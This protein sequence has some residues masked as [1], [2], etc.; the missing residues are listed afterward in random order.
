MKA[1]P[2]ADPPRIADIERGRSPSVGEHLDAVRQRTGSP[3]GD[4]FANGICERRCCKEGPAID[5]I[6]NRNVLADRVDETV[7]MGLHPGG[8]LGIDQRMRRASV[9]RQR[10]VAIR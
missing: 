7:I 6:V 10:D 2:D 4:C 3:V 1:C 5:R 8:V 9:D